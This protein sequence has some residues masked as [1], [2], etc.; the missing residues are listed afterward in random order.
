[1]AW[2][3]KIEAEK[4]YSGYEVSLVALVLTFFGATAL[5]VYVVSDS[6]WFNLGVLGGLFAC[7]VGMGL[8]AGIPRITP[9]LNSRA[10]VFGFI[11]FLAVL[12]ISAFIHLSSALSIA[13]TSTV[14]FAAIA[15]EW[16]FRFGLQRLLERF[17]NPWIALFLQAGAF[18]VYH[19]RV[20][21]GYNFTAAAFPLIAG[22]IFGVIN[23]V[24][25]DIS[26]SML[27]HFLNN[28][29]TVVIAWI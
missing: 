2:V 29:F 10:L 9:R 22:L 11:G 27:A 20:Y 1:M 17:T 26:A 24:S 3:K 4:V 13:S 16:F 12:P 23:V 14:L 18:M 21:P 8:I 28:L 19:W 6:E 5:F 7:G 25:K 15:E